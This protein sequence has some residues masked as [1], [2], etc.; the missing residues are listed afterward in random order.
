MSY[1]SASSDGGYSYGGAFVLVSML[2]TAYVAHFNA[3]KFANQLVSPTDARRVVNLSISLGSNEKNS[4]NRTWLS[5]LSLV[6]LT[7]YNTEASRTPASP[8]CFAPFR[9]PPE[10]LAKL[11]GLAFL[12]AFAVT[13]PHHKLICIYSALFSNL[14]TI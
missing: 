1:L 12:C 14:L 10:R 8:L 9:R 6:P 5:V 4:L 7:P 11:C 13:G 3:P 2:S